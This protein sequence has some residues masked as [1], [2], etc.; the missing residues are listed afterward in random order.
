MDRARGSDRGPPPDTRLLDVSCIHSSYRQ[1]ARRVVTPPR[2]RALARAQHHTH[3]TRHAP[4]DGRQRPRR[5]ERTVD[6]VNAASAQERSEQDYLHDQQPRRHASL[7]ARNP[8]QPTRAASAGVSTKK[9]YALAVATNVTTVPRIAHDG[10]A[11]R[12]RSPLRSEARTG[13]VQACDTRP[14]R[15]RGRT[16]TAGTTASS[17]ATPRRRSSSWRWRRSARR[18]DGRA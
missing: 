10:R 4:M 7:I 6:E 16:Q 8:I 2:Q 13:H 1:S 9:T 3:T 11:R 12:A 17:R 14:D 5:S 15:T 18:D